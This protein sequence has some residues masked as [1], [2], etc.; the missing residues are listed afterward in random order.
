MTYQRKADPGPITRLLG[1][2]REIIRPYYLRNFYFPLYPAR[3]PESFDAAWRYPCVYPAG[4]R[5]STPLQAGFPD[6]LFWP[7]ND[8]HSRIQR[9]QQLAMAF[10]RRG[11]RCIYVNPHLGREFPSRPGP[12]DAVRLCRIGENL[13]EL[14][15]HLPR[16]PVF[17]HRALTHAESGHIAEAAT[18]ILNALRSEAV[19]Q[20]AAFPIWLDAAHAVRY[21]RQAALIYDCHDHLAGFAGISADIVALERKMIAE[22]DLVLCSSGWL[23]EKTSVSA[24]RAIVLRNAASREN[25]VGPPSAS[26]VQ[27]RPRIGYVGALE[28]WFDAEAIAAAARSRPGLDFELVGRVDSPQV[29]ALAG[30]AN[31]RLSGEIPYDQISTRLQAFSAALIPFRIND[32]IR[33]TDPIKVYE[34]LA[35]GL[36]VVSSALPEL[37]RLG[38]LIFRYSAPDDLAIQIDRALLENTESGRAERIAF[39]R[40]ET[41]DA[42]CEVLRSEIASLVN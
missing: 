20:I 12:A 17:H 39:A 10:A 15:V 8:W 32:L 33:A 13:F 30:I 40:S 38:D 16:E 4:E 36:P 11:H 31:V 28:S 24:R 18:L 42:R 25:F 19:V 29:A 23:L 37:D 26:G 22:S 35:A 27:S 3:K 2:V 14:H 9:S 6:V 1:S 21:D 34:Y 5:I 7:M 41:W